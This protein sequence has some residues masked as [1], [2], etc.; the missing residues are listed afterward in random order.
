[1][2]THRLLAKNDIKEELDNTRIRELPQDVKYNMKKNEAYRTS[3]YRTP[4]K[5]GSCNLAV[6][7]KQYNNKHTKKKS[8]G[9]LDC[10][11]EDKIFKKLDNIYELAEIMKNDRQSYK[12]EIL[13]KYGIPLISFALLPLFG[14]VFL[15]LFGHDELGRGIIDFCFHT[16]EEHARGSL[17]SCNK[18]RFH[19]YKK[20]FIISEYVNYIYMFIMFIIVILVSMYIIIKIMKYKKIKVGKDKMNIK[21]YYRFCKDIF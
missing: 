20:L 5:S 1:M 13:K 11:F 6:H 19:D 17:S 2:K 4:N 7:K 3:T 15:I 8:L 12:K 9:N 21:E 14:L 16:N 10:Y 18:A